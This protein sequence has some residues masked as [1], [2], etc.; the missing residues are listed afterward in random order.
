MRL[1]D[2]HDMPRD[3]LNI[4]LCILCIML[5]VAVAVALMIRLADIN[6]SLAASPL[7]Y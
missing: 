5:S 7:S 6:C 4:K 3:W 2:I 1:C